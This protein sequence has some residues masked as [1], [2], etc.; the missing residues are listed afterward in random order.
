[1]GPQFEG[2]EQVEQIGRGGFGTV[3]RAY[4]IAFRRRVAIKVLSVGPSDETTIRRFRREVGAV[5]SLSGHPHIVVVHDIG[6]TEQGDPYLVMA[7]LSGGTLGDRIHAGGGGSWRAVTAWTIKL[8]GALEAAH[9]AGVLHLDVKPDNVLFDEFE[10]PQLVD[11]GI[12]RLEGVTHSR[13]GHVKATPLYA[14]PEV[15]SGVKPSPSADVYSLAATAY[16]TLRGRPAFLED[17]DETLA[18]MLTRVLTQPP[19]P[20]PEAVLPGP[21]W[22]VLARALAKGPEGRQASAGQFG[23][24]LQDAQREVGVPVTTMTIPGGRQDEDAD[25]RTVDP[26]PRVPTPVSEDLNATLAGAASTPPPGGVVPTLDDDDGR[27]PRTGR[28]RGVRLLLF[29]VVLAVAA[30]AGLLVAQLLSDDDEPTDEVTADIDP[31]DV[32]PADLS[33]PS[34]ENPAARPTDVG[35]DARGDGNQALLQWTNN[36]PAAQGVA[37]QVDRRVITVLLPD[38]DEIVIDDVEA[39]ARTCFIVGAVGRSGTSWAEA[40]ACSVSGAPS[41]PTNVNA[42]RADGEYVEISWSDAASNEQGYRVL[43]DGEV[44]ARLAP[45]RVSAAID[46]V[47]EA[48]RACFTVV[49]F[50]EA[51]EAASDEVCVAAR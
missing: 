51:G 4:Q 16:A 38:Q 12:A 28:Q 2:C 13:S 14:A 49:A 31:A 44:V 32:P 26:V 25:T 7:H 50:N 3:Y 19:D 46:D 43:Q 27:T 34:A 20:L 36:A 33:S 8:A 11:F 47:P 1:M 39:D 22:A 42:E 9:K 10:E 29:L 48:A 5:G 45:G 24:E 17:T 30:G 40:P 23:R 15:L 37:V 35:V 21:I 18:P 6:T 41:A